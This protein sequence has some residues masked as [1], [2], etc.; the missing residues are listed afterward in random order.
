MRKLRRHDERSAGGCKTRMGP[1]LHKVLQGEEAN[2]GEGMKLKVWERRDPHK[3]R[4][5]HCRELYDC[6]CSQP[7]G[8]SHAFVC[9]CQYVGPVFDRNE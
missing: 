6:R 9:P 3:V 8:G 2:Q 1:I 4:C 7:S 5:D